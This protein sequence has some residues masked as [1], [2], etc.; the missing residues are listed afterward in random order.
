[1]ERRRKKKRREWQGRRR[2]WRGGRGGRK[3][4]RGVEGSGRTATKINR[5]ERTGRD[6]GRQ[7]GERH[8]FGCEGQRPR[9][10]A[11]AVRPSRAT[12][13]R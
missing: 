5:R 1:M 6:S 11:A 12:A 7:G 13:A 10:E 8:T 9:K 3:V 4:Q 2:R